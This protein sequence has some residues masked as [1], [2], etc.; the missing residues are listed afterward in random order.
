MVVFDSFP[1][2]AFAS[3]VV[4]AKLPAVLCLRQVNNP[5]RYLHRLADFLPH[6]HQILI[7]MMRVLFSCREN[8]RTRAVLWERS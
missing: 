7:P 8:S 2:Q 1:D 3:A 6:V 5:E 4:G